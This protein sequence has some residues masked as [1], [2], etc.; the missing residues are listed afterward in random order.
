MINAAVARRYAKA[1]LGAALD[2]NTAQDLDETAR[3]MSTLAETVERFNGLELLLLNP[4]IDSR[5][6]AA[7]LGEV[8]E[9]LGAG[10]LTRRFIDVLA[11]H[12]R[13][14]HLVASAKSFTALVDDHH[15][16]INAEI[17]SPE[18]LS[19]TELADLR[20]RLA[21]TTGRTVRLQART[22]PELFGG[23]RTR[24]G[25]IVYDGSLRHQ[26]ERMRERLTES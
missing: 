6:K 8:A 23:L 16:V 12:E 9:R 5:R 3:E 4:A 24:I 2:V 7:V 21:S 11:D 13:I 26:L 19:E 10:E 22:D 18:P 15:G 1:L 14:D 25:D 17:T 20:D